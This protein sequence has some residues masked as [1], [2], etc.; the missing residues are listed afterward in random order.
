MN[1]LIKK[2]ESIPVP[3]D[4]IER[5]G[6]VFEENHG[7]RQNEVQIKMGCTGLG[8]Y[9]RVAHPFERRFFFPIRNG[10]PASS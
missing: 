8:G 10:R 4:F 3:E 7:L 5:M 1:Y 9:G 6:E 2:N